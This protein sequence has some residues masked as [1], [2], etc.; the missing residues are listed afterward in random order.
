MV[1]TASRVQVATIKI[2][3]G[4]QHQEEPELNQSSEHVLMA[5]YESFKSCR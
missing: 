3:G 1:G 4:F 2:I 5:L